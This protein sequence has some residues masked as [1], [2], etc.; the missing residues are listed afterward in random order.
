MAENKT[1]YHESGEEGLFQFLYE[2]SLLLHHA[3]EAFFRSG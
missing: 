1:N 2:E 3:Q